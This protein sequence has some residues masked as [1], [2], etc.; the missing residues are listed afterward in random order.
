MSS[1]ISD[2]GLILSNDDV[3]PKKALDITK[4]IFPYMDATKLTLSN[5]VHDLRILSRVKEET[6][7]PVIVDL[8]VAD[9]GFMNQET[10]LWEGTNAS[11]VRTFINAGADYITCHTFPGTSSI[12][13]CVEVAHSIGGKILT[14]PYMSGR[15]AEL[16]FGQPIH[17]EYTNRTLH[18]LGI[19][20]DSRGLYT[21]SDLVLALGEYFEVDGYIGPANNLQVLKRYREHTQRPVYGPGIGRQATDDLSLREQL[22]QFYRIC[23]RKSAAIIGS[24][25]YTAPDP[26]KAAEEFRIWRDDIVNL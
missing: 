11:I 14:L 5:T 3:A 2:Y 22:E 20:L 6:N 1:E 7:K 9:I 13:E 25:I 12:Q 15:G 26:V 18:E 8:K 4:K 10:S 16:F 23:G 24:A 19:P 17:L 21:I